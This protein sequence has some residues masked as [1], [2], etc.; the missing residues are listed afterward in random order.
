[1]KMSEK[2]NEVV[3]LVIQV[4]NLLLPLP[5]P[6]P[7]PRGLVHCSPER[8][9]LVVELVVRIHGKDRIEDSLDVPLL[10]LSPS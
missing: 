7:C 2:G 1:M 4:V 6:L 10:S 9:V 5:L 8:I 3:F